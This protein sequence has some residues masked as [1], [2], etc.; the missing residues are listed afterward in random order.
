MRTRKRS[1]MFLLIVI[2]ALCVSA[3]PFV[4][5][6]PKTVSAAGTTY[7]KTISVDTTWSDGTE[8]KD[9]T[10]YQIKSGV[11]VTISGKVR[12]RNNVISG[13]TIKF[14][15]SKS[16]IDIVEKC[17]FT[18]ENAT[19]DG[20][21]NGSYNYFIRGTTSHS[22]VTANFNNSTIMNCDK[23][24]DVFSGSTV[25]INNS[26]IKDCSGNFYLIRATGSDS[27]TI[28]VSSG[29]FIDN[30]VRLFYT[31]KG[32]INI[33]GGIFTNNSK[34]VIRTY[35]QSTVTINGGTFT[36]NSATSGGVI[37]NDN[38]IVTIN[39]GTFTNNS[40]N[41]NGGVIYN[42]TAGDKLNIY[43]GHF[44]D[45]TANGV[46]N[47][48]YNKEDSVIDLNIGSTKIPTRTGYTY[49]GWKDNSGNIYNTPNKLFTI[50]GAGNGLT[51]IWKANSYTI[52]YSGMEN[53]TA[54]PMPATH[55]YGTATPIGN[56]TKRGYTFSGWKVNNAP[57]VKDLVLGATDYT[58]GISL[59]A[60]WTANT[61]N[62]R[63]KGIEGATIT[64]QPT[65]HTYGAATTVGNPTKT[66]Y[67]FNGWKVNSSTT[68]KTD[69]TL[70]A[71][72]Y[73]DDITLTATWT[74]N[75]YNIKYVGLDGAALT[76]KPT[77]HTYGTATTVGNPTKTGYTF[78]GWK[79]NNGATA[80]TD[81]TLGATDY[82][83][84]I[85]LTATWKVHNYTIT[86]NSNKPTK[87][88]HDVTGTTAKSYC[89]Y[90]VTYALTEN[91]YVLTGWTFLGW[92]KD[93]NATTIDYAD[94]AEVSNLTATDDGNVELYAIWKANTYTV[95]YVSDKSASGTVLKT[96]H[97]YDSPSLLSA[98]KYT[99]KGWTFKG[100]SRTQGSDEVDFNAGAIV[101][102]LTDIDGD[103]VTLYAVWSANKYK[104]AYRANKP[105]T[106]TA[107][108]KG[109]MTDSDFI[110]DESGKLSEIGYLLTGWTFVGWAK[111]ADG[112]AEFKNAAE[113][114]NLTENDGETIFLY[115][116]WQANTFNISFDTD[117]GNYAE[118]VTAAY[119]HALVSVTPPTRKGYNFNG[120]F[121]EPDGEGDKYYDKDGIPEIVKYT[122][123]GGIKLYASWSPVTYNIELY[124]EGVFVS[125]ITGV[126]YGTLRLPSAESLGL[127]RANYTFVGWNIYDEQNWR[128]YSADVE[129]NAG[130]ADYEGET[131]VIYA[132]W[133]E[134]DK[135]TIEFDPNGGSGAPGSMLVHEDETVALS[136]V[137]P[138]RKNYTF[139]GW[140]VKADADSVD[141]RP[142]DNFTMGRELVTLYAVWKLNPSLTY[143]ANGG[144]FA[145]PV[146][147]AY[148]AEG[149][150]I[151]ITSLVPEFTGY[152]F[153]GWSKQSDATIA[154]YVSLDEFVMPA[155][156]T[157]LYAV[158]NI[159]KYT[160]TYET[161]EGYSVTGLAASYEY[162]STVTFE[163]TGSSP[164]VY[165]D[166]Q[167]LTAG[168]DGKY[169]FVIKNNSRIFVANGSKG[170]LIYSAN[171]G[172]N[173]PTDKGSYGE[174][175]MATIS[176]DKP[177]RVG[178][179]FLGWATE[180]DATSA[181]YASGDSV[182]FSADK[183]IVIYAVWQ[184]NVYNVVYNANGGNGEM[185]ESRFE[186]GAVGTLSKNT[187]E[188]IGY[189]FIGWATS[190]TG[191][192]VYGDG[193]AVSDLSPIN[194]FSVNLYAVWERTVT[195]IT[196]VSNGGSDVN[197]PISVAY[198][199]PL[200]SDG[201][202][203]PARVGYNFLGYNTQRDGS[204]KYIFNKE[205]KVVSSSIWDKNVN[206]ITLYAVWSP[207]S[208]NVVYID[209]QKIIDSQ[210]VLYGESFY[211]KTYNE[212]GLKAEL[213]YHFAGW[214]T[215][216][217]GKIVAYTDNQRITSALASTDGAEVLL[218]AVYAVDE[219]FSV[220]YYANG[221][222]NAPVDG[223][224]YL[225]GELVKFS[226]VI[227]VREGYIFGGWSY[228]PN[229][230]D[231]DFVYANGKFDPESI[232]MPDGG[233]SL[234]AIWI[235]DGD[236]VLT[237]IGKL[238]EELQEKVGQLGKTDE[239]LTDQLNN[240]IK[241]LATANDEIEKIT[242][243]YVTS[244][245]LKA[246]ID[247]A[248][249]ELKETCDAADE[250]LLKKINEIDGKLTK[251]IED[252]T[253]TVGDNKTSIEGELEKVKEA[254]QLADEALKSKIGSL[255]ST[256]T[257]RISKLE[258]TRKTAD[259]D[260]QK[261]IDKVQEN[262]TNAVNALNETISSNKGD[263]ES[264]LTAV[265]NAYKAADELI[266]ADLAKLTTA[267]GKLD[268][269]I[270]A[271]EKASKEADEDLQKAI[272]K[273]QENLTNAV[274]ALNETI[275]SNKGDIESKLTAVENAY[276]AADELI[277]ADLAKLRTKDG[278]LEE[279]IAALKK[280][281]EAADEA[282]LAGIKQVQDNLDELRRQLE[283]KDSDLEAK[284]NSLL[285]DSDKNAKTCL[286]INIILGVAIIVLFVLQIIATIKKKSSKQ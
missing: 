93:P 50:S 225:V 178:Y 181:T 196:F 246:A 222:S 38:S 9:N 123:N 229:K 159:A 70:G 40:A 177:E 23:L 262:L 122:V 141:Y 131:A 1:F 160:V 133:L 104:V 60:T 204:G 134:K 231:I 206:A 155:D 162:G 190:P 254:Y 17:T 18:V 116:V 149:E 41:T 113:I 33:D 198:G 90:G 12:A 152:I 164:K 161:A 241:D 191:E 253:K 249:A 101:K 157:I 119:D 263:I 217:S 126:K 265:E 99:I 183:D 176:N 264:K 170:S 30:K 132:A 228:D 89:E 8:L 234:Y 92:A 200:L 182:E 261:A 243:D 31:S 209:G 201:L 277:N 145:V 21:N 282:L 13:G 111:T 74:A 272:D 45:N 79:V 94:S 6:A 128:M 184:A 280:A 16:Y 187:F 95:N 218:Y 112:E 20:N 85:T 26:T 171:G 118:T 65:T 103:E 35:N 158:W 10:T 283:N 154:D 144:K 97:T 86:Y 151:R 278:E 107:D 25:N 54:D 71:T 215:V 223:N 232:A 68:A 275:S 251:A 260:L 258:D 72:D 115:A 22:E 226:S 78:N 76:P 110:Y 276:K 146:E 244:G 247:A 240:L 52:N 80:K 248:I 2:A 83:A 166:G 142:G 148:P 88:S 175:T 19:I 237:R 235:L 256:L 147:K 37:V 15:D 61:Y 189:T 62:I 42:Y 216:P 169:S 29:N 137:I 266:N 172:A 91:G 174:G 124:S 58:A 106:A 207:V 43:G 121:T 202:E 75:T 53:A 14:S 214:S 34:G 3:L 82:T 69:L 98:S 109:E 179:T 73:T 114:I 153:R 212:L 46:L 39:G 250:A 163:V 281:S 268:E 32:I 242:N 185:A 224:K 168:E 140:C 24:I 245:S 87:A 67:T 150:T 4:M 257:E 129:Y 195:K 269:K 117:G 48:V 49:G 233:L 138:S 285:A 120:Y 55:T 286:I 238:N 28:N 188:K 252:L 192:V 66:G 7:I 108:I 180:A 210:T 125:L 205:M 219:E 273:V 230:T 267:D 274:N 220:I 44:A 136:S 63:Y 211:L 279:S 255:N 227:P 84:D 27:P 239:N 167:L 197:A 102:T 139:L 213:G 127:K 47:D 81:L 57:A 236:S 130:L 36:N 271:L 259:E 165:V 135:F 143:D 77:T 105:D 270:T 100:W 5:T 208:Y 156:D 284:L 59:E 51:I 11:T 56:P 194:D 186:F 96:N 193:A 203:A 64:T 199:E 221:G 173:A